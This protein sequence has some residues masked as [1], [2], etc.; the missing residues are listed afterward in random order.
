MTLP[1]LPVSGH[2][3]HSSIIPPMN[4]HETRVTQY[5]GELVKHLV[6]ENQRMFTGDDGEQQIA[7]KSVRSRACPD[8]HR[9]I[10]NNSH[11][12]GA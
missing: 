11:G 12:W 9:G 2:Q 1:L 5:L 6:G 4:G 8:E 3:P 7:G 10:Q